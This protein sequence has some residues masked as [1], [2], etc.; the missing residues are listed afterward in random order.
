VSCGGKKYFS[1]L[2]KTEKERDGEEEEEE[3]S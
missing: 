1:R 3:K 2:G